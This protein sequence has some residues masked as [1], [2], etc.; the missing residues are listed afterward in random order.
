MS[1]PFM[2]RGCSVRMMLPMSLK[3]NT[4]GHFMKI[5]TKF[6][7]R[8]ETVIGEDYLGVEIYRFYLRCLKCSALS[9]F[10]TDPKN[11]NY[12][13]EEGVTRNYEPWRDVEAA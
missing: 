4:C 3:C 7:M 1:D 12:V 10:K 13:V 8:K 9:T 6:N 5:G 11:S 2:R